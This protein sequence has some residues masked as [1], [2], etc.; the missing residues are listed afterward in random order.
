MR[1]DGEFGIIYVKFV[2][3]KEVLGMFKASDRCCKA[4]LLAAAAIGF[5]ALQAAA[6]QYNGTT[7]TP[8]NYTTIL[9]AAES[10][11]VI[12]AAEGTYSN[13]MTSAAIVSVK[14]GVSF[15]AEHGYT[16]TFIKGDGT[17][18]LRGASL[19]SGALLRGFTICGTYYITAP[20]KGNG[21]GVS[22]ASNAWVV[23]CVISNNVASRGGAGTN[24]NFFRCRFYNNTGTGKDL[25][26]DGTGYRIIGCLFG[27]TESGYPVYL[28][29]ASS[30]TIVN[31]TFRSTGPYAASGKT[32]NVYNSLVLGSLQSRCA[33][34]DSI[35]VPSDSANCTF[36][37]TLRGVSAASI[38]L[39][40]NSVPGSTSKARDYSATTNYTSKITTT[41]VNLIGADEVQKDLHGKPRILNGKIDT[42]C[43][44]FDCRPQFAADLS[45][46][47]IVEVLSVSSN[48]VETT[49]K[50][51]SIPDDNELTISVAALDGA[52][53]TAFSYC[54]EI[55]GGGVLSVYRDGA[56]SPSWTLTEADGLTNVSFNAESDV[57]LRFAYSGEG[58]ATLSQV[59]NTTE[60]VILAPDAGL[61]VDGANIGTNV[62]DAGDTLS[63]TLHRGW[64]SST[65]LRGV[66]V[67]GVFHDFDDYPDGLSFSISAANR[68][69]A[70]LFEA[71][72]ATAPLTW[73]VDANGGDD[74]NTGF[75]PSNAFKTVIRA[76]TNLAL[77]SGATIKL[78]PGRYDEGY[79]KAK[80]AWTRT[81]ARLPDGVTM[82]STDGADKTFIV[83]APSPTPL[84][85]SGWGLGTNCVRCLL[86]GKGAV[87]RGVTLA[88]GRAA[89]YAAD[90][91]SGE[92]GGGAAIISGTDNNNPSYLVDVVITNCHAY[93]AGG[94]NGSIDYIRCKIVGCGATYHTGG[95][96]YGNL[97]NCVVDRCNSYAVH[98]PYLAVN[99]TMGP[100]NSS[101]SVRENDVVDSHIYN[102]LILGNTR[103][104]ATFHRC[105]I[106]GSDRGG[107]FIDGCIYPAGGTNVVASVD[108]S[109][110][111]IKTDGRNDAVDYGSSQFYLTKFPSAYV[112]ERMKD[113]LGG[114]RFYCGNIDVGAAE[115]DPRD[116]FAK[117]LGNRI[118]VTYATSNVYDNA[119]SVRL[120]GEGAA[121]ALDWKSPGG[122]PWQFEMSLEVSGSG[123]LAVYRNGADEPFAT[124]TE[125]DG[126]SRVCFES[127]GTS[128]SL[129]FVFSGE[130]HA[131]L[132]DF[133]RIAGT[134]IMIL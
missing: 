26:Y 16:N 40:S 72:Y 119:S 104:N 24:A 43:C 15:I 14:A 35:V 129:R 118:S 61:V 19:G 39:D 52:Q 85:K 54:A 33:Y 3:G 77:Q 87:L 12:Y 98:N 114:Q 128:D 22:G 45:S 97:F 91:L 10:G 73:Y 50:L 105:V 93:I 84:G 79:Y 21:G 86:I 81:R 17:T 41:L 70:S 8:E 108:S 4:S 18:V 94:G 48:V 99:C 34:Y 69:E 20:S 59:A 121:L 76:T 126:R 47:G 102:C 55:A 103:G 112:G 109:Y 56:S 75:H 5:A 130:G 89:I 117:M 51:L 38:A 131:D 120:A 28:N 106:T 30:L 62:V 90:G 65:L 116:D 29:T 31:S 111:L 83:G 100:N 46:K 66:N 9:A 133:K 7:V 13:A 110:R 80:S 127:D 53:T 82:E 132:S 124:L 11:D 58:S 32:I 37:N 88:D 23:D 36:Y 101:Y 42:G 64:D 115:Y 95:T 125:A 78:L 27:S 68:N 71:V 74:A 2:K 60:V 63:F 44:E 96:Q 123:T 113:F 122:R 57:T 92:Q 107:T 25:Y 67:D 134:V 6:S 1:V 49:D